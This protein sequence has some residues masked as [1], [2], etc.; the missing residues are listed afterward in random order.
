[1]EDI[2]AP[3]EIKEKMKSVDTYLTVE[4]YMMYGIARE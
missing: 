1:M 3:N 2:S 4:T